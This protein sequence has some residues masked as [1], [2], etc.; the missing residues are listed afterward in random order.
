MLVLSYGVEVSPKGQR[1]V[2]QENCCGQTLPLHAYVFVCVAGMRTS[3]QSSPACISAAGMFSSSLHGVL[4]L[5][6]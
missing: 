4:M 5:L 2:P 3:M 1:S 6:Q